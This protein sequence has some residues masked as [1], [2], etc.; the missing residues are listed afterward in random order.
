MSP[1][2]KALALGQ[3]GVWLSVLFVTLEIRAL[4]GR[5]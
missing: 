4:R 5:R 2:E 1:F 3:L